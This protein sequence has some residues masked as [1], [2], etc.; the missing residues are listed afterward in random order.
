M[1]RAKPHWCPGSACIRLG[2]EMTRRRSGGLVLLAA[3][4]ACGSDDAAPSDSGPDTDDPQ[5]G[6]QT[7][8]EQVGCLAVESRDLA[9]SELSPLGFSADTLLRALGA[10]RETRL[11]WADGSSTPL[12]LTLERSTGAVAFE[13]REWTESR[14]GAEPALAPIGAGNELALPQCNDVVSLPV[15]MRVT[16]SDGAFAEQLTVRLLAE[17]ATRATAGATLDAQSLTGSFR[18]TAL[19]PAAYDR[20][21]VNVSLT[22]GSEAWSGTVSGQAIDDGEP[23]GDGTASARFFDIGAF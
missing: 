19:D 18:V 16:T 9:W 17:S 5:I 22:L 11:T 12:T 21:L 13:E 8:E 20:V 7:G 3:A 15:S 6:G 23:S 10:E 14:S 1:E 4:L 2:I